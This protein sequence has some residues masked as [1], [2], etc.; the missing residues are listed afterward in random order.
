MCRSRGGHTRD[1]SMDG[2]PRPNVRL[3]GSDGTEDAT[4]LSF[5]V[6]VSPR[7]YLLLY[8]RKHVDEQEPGPV[9]VSELNGLHKGPG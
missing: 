6:A 9:E 2:W 7:A 3:R 1:A 4:P 5:W 8:G